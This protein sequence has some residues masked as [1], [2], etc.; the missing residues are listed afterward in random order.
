MKSEIILI[1]GLF[2][3][4]YH[5]GAFPDYLQN[6]FPNKTITLIDAPGN[7]LLFSKDSPMSIEGMVQSIRQQRNVRTKVDIVA[8][9][10]GGM[11]GLKWAE[12][13][14]E[15]VDTL[16]C[17]NTSSRGFSPFY[18][19]LLPRNYLTILTALSVGILK[20]E[21]I[22]YGLVSN[23]NLDIN[24][25]EEWATYGVA[26]PLKKC[27]F[28]R[29]LVAALK[30]EVTCPAC[31][32]FFISSECDRFVD[33]EATKIMAL[34]WGKPLIIN[35]LDGHDIPLDNPDWLSK[36]LSKLINSP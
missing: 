10:M 24:V 12:M 25:V 16:V 31:R 18:Q 20:R 28:F 14:P 21:A 6:R 9:S 34:E 35:Q 5:W 13:Y 2:R 7:G 27:N 30:F 17:I 29:Q 4:S 11:I 33:A 1:R 36:T 8:I 3:G 32:L 23:K 26:Y 15:E 22:V 19:R